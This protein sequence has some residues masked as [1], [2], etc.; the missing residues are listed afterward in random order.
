[1]FKKIKRWKS[2]I[3]IAKLADKLLNGI[4][5]EQKL[6]KNIF[7]S[8]TFWLNILALLNELVKLIPMNPSIQDSITLDTATLA[9]AL[10]LANV[11]V[12]KFTRVPVEIIPSSDH[13]KVDSK[14]KD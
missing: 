5:E 10:P 13:K 14:Y 11:V 3:K 6:K 2:Y 4:E 1:M 8:K 9:V 12:R 7:T